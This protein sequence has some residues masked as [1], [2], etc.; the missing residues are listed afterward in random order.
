MERTIERYRI[1]SAR[2]KEYDYSTPNWYFV[3]INTKKHQ[4]YFGEV[5]N[6]KMYL[7]E[8]GKIVEEYWNKIT[9]HYNMVQL[10]YF[11]IMPNHVHGIII[12]D[13]IVETGHAPSLQKKT[14][15]LG[16]IIGSFKSAVTK[17][18]HEHDEKHFTWQSRFYD[19]I[20]RNERELN[21]IRNYIE[22][23]PLRWELDYDKETLEL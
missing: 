20:I 7:N 12:L 3:T 22:Q 15:T 19:R 23:N 14:H 13:Y 16:N 8:L 1:P 10:D 21:A 5:K 18:L 11:V 17:Q 4:E 6:G 2:L 9:E